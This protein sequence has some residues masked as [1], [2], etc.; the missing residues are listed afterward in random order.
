MAALVEGRLAGRIA[1]VSG[2]ANGIGRASALRL[3][4]EGADLALVDREGD[5]LH[6]VAREIE[7]AGRQVLAI[8][9]DWTDTHAVHQAFG[10]IR[11]RFGRDIPAILVT[12]SANP[13][14]VSIAQEK[15]FHYLLKPV[16][17][18]KLRTLVNFKIKGNGAPRSRT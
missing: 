12:G 17:P 10:T 4:R 13:Q 5:P 18:A 15:G 7:T 2:A 6:A 11:Q 8:T 3:A 9:T 14:L 1:L 16:M